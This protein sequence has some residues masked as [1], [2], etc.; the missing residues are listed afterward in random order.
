MWRAVVAE[1]L[2]TFVGRGTLKAKGKPAPGYP[3]R[4]G[5]DEPT[6]WGGVKKA[7]WDPTTLPGMPPTPRPPKPKPSGSLAAMLG[8]R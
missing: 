4:K 8:R 6:I 7:G 3:T 2:A 1:S 5:L